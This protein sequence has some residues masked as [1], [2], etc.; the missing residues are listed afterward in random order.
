MK[1]KK[2]KKL[3]IYGLI[4]LLAIIILAIVV[5]TIVKKFKEGDSSKEWEP[6][7]KIVNQSKLDRILYDFNAFSD[8]FKEVGFDEATCN[9]EEVM[10]MDPVICNAFKTVF[11][12]SDVEDNLALTFNGEAVE[13]MSLRL[14]YDEAMFKAEAIKTDANNVINNL[15]DMDLDVDVVDKLVTAVTEEATEL[16]ESDFQDSGNY[17]IFYNLKF[18]A[19]TEELPAYYDTNLVFYLK[20]SIIGL[21]TPIADEEISSSTESSIMDR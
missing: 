15:I 12:D 2:N 16:G 20:E 6:R 7:Y 4:V 8:E 19:E 3:I 18:V 21:D 11:K 14:V 5:P 17:R 9:D 10:G 1:N 13:T